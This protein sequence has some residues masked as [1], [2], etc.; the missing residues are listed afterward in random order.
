MLNSMNL[1]G[2]PGPLTAR[3]TDDGMAAVTGHARRS[4][5]IHVCMDIAWHSSPSLMT[6]TMMA[7]TVAALALHR[8]I[9]DKMAALQ[10]ALHRSFPDTM[11]VL[12]LIGHFGRCDVQ[13]RTKMM[14][15]LLTRPTCGDYY[16]IF[17]DGP[18]R[19]RDGWLVDTGS[20]LGQRWMVDAQQCLMHNN[21]PSLRRGHDGALLGFT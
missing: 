2:A 12:L 20:F 21:G 14:V 13:R 7:M 8:S 17:F 18:L 19:A 3:T 9:L 1:V 6:T 5:I 4:Y 16:T 15:L 11:E 10:L